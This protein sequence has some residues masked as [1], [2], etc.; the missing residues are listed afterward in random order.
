M[1]DG[2]PADKNLHHGR[3]RGGG[4]GSDV[5]TLLTCGKQNN[6]M[7]SLMHDEVILFIKRAERK[8]DPFFMKKSVLY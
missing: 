7:Q 6:Q 2:E 1:I 5:K 8:G 4:G 3:T